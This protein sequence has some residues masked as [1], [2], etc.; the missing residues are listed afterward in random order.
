MRHSF[1]R[2]T[3]KQK[4]YKSG[5]KKYW[6]TDK[7]YRAKSSHCKRTVTDGHFNKIKTNTGESSMKWWWV[8][9]NL[10]LSVI[11]CELWIWLPTVQYFDGLLWLRRTTDVH[12]V[13]FNKNTRVFHLKI[14][15]VCLFDNVQYSFFA[16]KRVLKS[17]MMTVWLIWSNIKVESI[18]MIIIS[19]SLHQEL[20]SW[21]PS[22]TAGEIL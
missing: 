19:W 22:T 2:H 12:V 18:W 20:C 1:T 6:L 17:S 10:K 14:S 9:F 7:N 5:V 16:I 11:N 15:Q 3:H 4:I 13:W 21:C 8:S